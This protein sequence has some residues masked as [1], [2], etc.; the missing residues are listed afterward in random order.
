MAYVSYKKLSKKKRRE[1]DQRKREI[2]GVISPATRSVG[3]AKV[4][5]RKKNQRQHT[6]LPTLDFLIPEAYSA[7]QVVSL[8]PSVFFKYPLHA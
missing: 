5:N 4:Y 2:W 8:A 6:E 1:V 7:E 3:S